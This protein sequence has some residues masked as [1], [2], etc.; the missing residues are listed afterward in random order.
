MMSL[1]NYAGHSR[2]SKQGF[3]KLAPFQQPRISFQEYD[4][5]QDCQ[6]EEKG[7]S[8]VENP[9]EIPCCFFSYL[10]PSY[11]AQSSQLSLLSTVEFFSSKHSFHHETFRVDLFESLW[12]LWIALIPF[13]S[14]WIALNCYESLW[15]ALNCFELLWITSNHFELLWIALN[16]FESLWI[17]LNRFF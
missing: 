1:W 13:E 14:L 5:S 6:T 3:W 15:I 10:C 4:D 12:M 16:C 11:S 8:D 17:T 7:C 9:R 2:S